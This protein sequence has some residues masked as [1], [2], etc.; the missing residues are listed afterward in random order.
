MKEVNR[1]LA[2]NAEEIRLFDQLDKEEDL[3]AGPLY[4]SIQDVPGWLQFSKD[5]EERAH[6]MLGHNRKKMAPELEKLLIY[7]SRYK[8]ADDPK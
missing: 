8:G 7:G 1:L 4:T 2:R 5:D 6:N 3:W